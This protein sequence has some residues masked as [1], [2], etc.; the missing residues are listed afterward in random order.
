M[1][2]RKLLR[3]AE[4][5]ER[6]GLRPATLRR[7]RWAGQGPAF[8]QVGGAIRYDPVDLEH[9]VTVGRRP[10]RDEARHGGSA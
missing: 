4:A 10:P 2:D 6:L 3:E 7:W 1:G 8:V 9:F 5:A